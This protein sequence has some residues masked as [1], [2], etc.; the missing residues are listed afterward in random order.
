MAVSRR[1]QLLSSSSTFERAFTPG[2]TQTGLGP[3]AYHFISPGFCTVRIRCWHC[4]D[5]NNI[6]NIKNTYAIT[7]Y[8]YL[9][10]KN[11]VRVDP[12]NLLG[13]FEHPIYEGLRGKLGNTRRIKLKTKKHFFVFTFI[14]YAFFKVTAK[15]HY[16]VA[17]ITLPV[18]W[19]ALSKD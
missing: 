8:I 13:N 15:K 14:L 19:S 10:Q 9:T 6:C 12:I 3:R 1:R 7:Q 5:L 18:H 4:I 2:Q 11:E 17:I 16:L